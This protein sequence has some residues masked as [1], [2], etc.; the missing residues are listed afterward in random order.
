MISSLCKTNQNNHIHVLGKD[1]AQT[2]RNTIY[3]EKMYKTNFTEQNKKFVL[4]LHYNGD[5]SYLFVN[6]VQQLK[7]KTKSSE[8]QRIPL[9][10]G[11]I[12]TDFT[13]SATKTGLYGN[14]YDFA[15]DYVL[16]NRVG[17]IYDTHRYSMKKNNIV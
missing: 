5:D 15:A 16:I 9:V 14:F 3:A 17:T 6:D 10:L 8:I 2:N 1:F 11:N 12:S 4:S 7:F 13:T